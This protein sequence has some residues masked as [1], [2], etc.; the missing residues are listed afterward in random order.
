MEKRTLGSQGL[1]VSALGLGCMG[2]SEFYGTRDDAQ[3]LE[4]IARALDLGL[5]LLDTAP[6]YGPF[7][8][9]ELVGR[10][11]RGRRE[12]VVLATK[13]GV[14]RD[15]QDPN[16]RRL[17]SRPATV[18][19]SCEDSLRRLGVERIDLFYQHRLDPN[20]PIEETVGAMAD[21]VRAGK[22]AHLGLCEIGPDTL[23]RAHRV[24]PIAAV[25]SEYSLFYREPEQDIL[26]AL[27]ELGVG[28]V[29]YS[30]LGRGFL[31]GRIRSPAD[32]DA[33][34]WRHNSPRFQSGNFEK[35]LQLVAT[36][37][38]LAEERGAT[39]AQIALAWLL[40]QGDDIVPIPGTKKLQRLEENLGALSI[41]LDEADI[42]RLEAAFTQGA[43]AGARYGTVAAPSTQR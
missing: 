1:T 37:E 38:A 29:P 31:T 13:F 41:G 25:Q 16:A 14:E 36:V 12:Q 42:D 22:V 28:F 26:P 6:M 27:R 40:A 5:T 17:D 19:A 39:P 35:N 24:H 9:E 32:L 43:V 21:L 2:M 34:D 18:K 30:P 11:I 10:A 3:S 4:T 7:I 33:T 8:N 23:Q 20:V 15:P